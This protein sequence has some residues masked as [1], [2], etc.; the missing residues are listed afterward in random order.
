MFI[1]CGSS[2]SGLSSI[3]LFFASLLAAALFF[4]ASCALSILFCF[5]FFA[6]SVVLYFFS[7]HAKFRFSF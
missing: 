7:I 4:L 5:A 6:S 1:R 2:S 3:G